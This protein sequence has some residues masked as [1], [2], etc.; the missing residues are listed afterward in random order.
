M[1]DIVYKTYIKCPI[2]KRAL[3]SI[4]SWFQRTKLTWVHDPAE[5]EIDK[6]SEEF[7]HW[8][9]FVVRV[10]TQLKLYGYAAY[11]LR[12][13]RGRP[14]K[15]AVASILE[16]ANGQN[17]AIEWKDS[18]WII[19]SVEGE[20]DD[21]GTW[22]LLVFDE[23][24]RVGTKNTPILN[25]SAA[26][27]QRESEL[28]AKIKERIE[29]RDEINTGPTVYTSISKNLV[30]G[31]SGTW[32]GNQGSSHIDAPGFGQDFNSMLA[33]RLDAIKDLERMSNEAR[34]NAR[35]AYSKRDSK[36]PELCPPEQ[37]RASE[38]FITDGREYKEM[39]H[40]RGP[41]ELHQILDRLSKEIM[42]T[43]EVTP[44]SFGIGGSSERLT[45]ND[46]L[47]QIGISNADQ[48]K[49]T[50]MTFVQIALSELS[51]KLSLDNTG[52]TRIE[53]KP[54]IS[55]FNFQQIQPFLKPAFAIKTLSILHDIPEEAL[56]KSAYKAYIR[57]GSDKGGTVDVA[58]G[59]KRRMTD[60]QIQ[61]RK[62]EKAM[63]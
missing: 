36:R 43:Y 62:D 14:K 24:T 18:E 1:A 4:V 48:H 8:M 57:N 47:A 2:Q 25:S 22:S 15:G 3:R 41:E 60:K 33:E 9:T 16:V 35:M 28:Y 63:P 46:R 39:S 55:A 58:G 10:V 34:Q 19:R 5:H 49:H 30:S 37:P 42:F 31:Q 40:R 59:K 27:C 61:E 52:K 53:I 29:L 20:V 45:S 50:L 26:N 7:R 38:L 13:T 44:Q 23:P 32:F 12:K 17:V 56:D 51:S 6:N 11:R 21:A 54:V